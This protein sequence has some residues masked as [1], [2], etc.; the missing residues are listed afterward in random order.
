M[1]EWL[2]QSGKRDWLT[3][4]LRWAPMGEGKRGL[5][6]RDIRQAVEASSVPYKDRLYRAF[7]GA[8]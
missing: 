5:S 7:S 3:S 6:S 8:R 1:G 2:E 4:P